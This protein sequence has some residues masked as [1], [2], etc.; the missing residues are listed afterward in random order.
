MNNNESIRASD[1]DVLCFLEDEPL[2]LPKTVRFVEFKEE[3]ERRIFHR[4]VDK[5]LMDSGVA[6]EL[7]Q[8]G[9]QGW[10]KGKLKIC[11]EFIPDKL[12]HSSELDVLRSRMIEQEVV[13][14]LDEPEVQ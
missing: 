7:L 11:I 1:V 10:E 3:L 9:S 5:S 14:L 2:S 6:C 8:P 13:D 12:N 4:D